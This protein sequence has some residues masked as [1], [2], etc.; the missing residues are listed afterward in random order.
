M[1]SLNHLQVPASS[2]AIIYRRNAT[3]STLS[4]QGYN[5]YKLPVRND[6]E[7][8]YRSIL[9]FFLAKFEFKMTLAA[10]NTSSFD[11]EAIVHCVK[12]C[13]EIYDQWFSPQILARM[14][15]LNKHSSRTFRVQTRSA[16]FF[17]R[18]CVVIQKNTHLRNTKDVKQGR[19]FFPLNSAILD[20]MFDVSFVA[21]E[22]DFSCGGKRRLSPF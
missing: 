3:L 5:S 18:S 20:Q 9:S 13:H 22:L 21:L 10:N 2:L 8:R 14:I 12:W 1:S 16:A 17:L 11:F 7:L 19:K 15:S 4:D 6:G